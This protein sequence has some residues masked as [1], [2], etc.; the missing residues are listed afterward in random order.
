MAGPSV[1]YTFSNGTAADGTQVNTNFTDLIN[2]ATDGT[3]DYSINAL[4]CAGAAT[5]NG[6]V[7]LGNASADDLTINASLASTIPIKTTNTYN[8]GSSTLGL[9][10]IYFGSSGGAFTT[11][12]LGAAVSS[13]ISLTL[14]STDGDSRDQISTDGSGVLS[15]VPI[16]RSVGHVSNYGLEISFNSGAMTITLEGAN[17]SALSSTNMVDVLFRNETAGTG[18]PNLLTLT[19]DRTLTIAS[20]ST[21]GTSSGTNHWIYVYLVDTD[22]TAANVKLAV[23]LKWLDEGSLQTTVAESG[24]GDSGTT[25]YASSSHSN[26][27]VRLIARMK[28]N[29]A[30]AGT[31]ATAMSEISLAPFAVNTPA[32]CYQTSAGQT[33]ETAGSGEIV[34]YGT[35]VFNTC[36]T[37][38]STTGV[39]TCPIEGVYRVSANILFESAAWAAN[40]FIDLSI[41]KNSTSII[42]NEK[43]TEAAVTTWVGNQVNGLL[44]CAAGDTIDIF[45]DHDRGTNTALLN[46]ATYNTLAI[47]WVGPSL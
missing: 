7:T 36:E 37:Y 21:L 44:D 41:R 20:G 26:R 46:L 13:S 22:G 11:R 45:I 15:F 24:N 35:K 5:L 6:N 43:T 47:E 2:G 18:T 32:I 42:V 33:I 4:T 25:L 38:D 3:K 8:I 17:G 29:Q 12:L 9:A 27:P 16:R 40:K 31:W 19:S 34:V 1:T 23:S 14:P 39:F 10:S 28:S 30:A